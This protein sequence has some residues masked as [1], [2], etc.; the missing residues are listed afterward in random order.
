MVIP[1]PCLIVQALPNVEYPNSRIIIRSHWTNIP[2]KT[3]ESVLQCIFWCESFWCKT[4]RDSAKIIN[5]GK[6]RGLVNASFVRQVIRCRVTYQLLLS[7][8]AV[9]PSL[10]F[11]KQTTGRPW[12]TLFFC[13]MFKRLIV[14]SHTRTRYGVPFECLNSSQPLNL[15][16]AAVV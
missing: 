8:S 3:R 7:H 15:T 1:V 2:N 12:I 14:F 13:T 5:I 11:A 16:C 10:V 4:L 6:P 9:G